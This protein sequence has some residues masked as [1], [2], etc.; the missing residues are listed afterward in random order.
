MNRALETLGWTLIHFCWQA[1]I[2]AGTYGLLDSRLRRARSE[3]RYL[4]SFVTLLLMFGTAAGTLAYETMHFPAAASSFPDATNS[5]LSALPSTSAMIA[6]GGQGRLT[7]FRLGSLLPWVDLAWLIGVVCFSTRTVAG[8]WCIQRLRRAALEEVPESVLAVCSK[9]RERLGISRIA[10]LRVCQHL[11]GP[12]TIGVARSLILL[13]AAALLSLDPEQLEAVLMHELA[14]VQRADYLWNLIQTSIETLFFFHPAV[15]WLGKRI[16][17]QRELCCD[18]LALAACADPLAY[19]TALLQIA[20]QRQQRIDLAM[21]FAGDRPQSGLRIRIARILGVTLPPA[22][23]W[24]ARPFSLAAI[25][26]ASLLFLSPLPR[27]F[28]GQSTPAIQNQAQPQAQ[29]GM[30]SL[31]APALIVQATKEEAPLQEP[32]LVKLQPDAKPAPAEAGRIEQM[33]TAGHDA[34][35]DKHAARTG[36]VMPPS[37]PGGEPFRSASAAANAVT[38]P[39]LAARMQ[40]AE[41]GPAPTAPSYLDGMRDAGYRLDLSKDFHTLTTMKSL[42]VTPEYAKA[43]GTVGLGKPTARDLI[44]L[45]SLGVTPEYIRGLK[46]SGIEPKDFHELAEEKSLAITPEYVAGLKQTGLSGLSARQLIVLKALRMTPEYAAWLKQQ[47]PQIT[48]EELRRAAILHIDQN[49]V[50]QAK[51]YGFDGKDLNELLRLKMSGLLN[52]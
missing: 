21:A 22:S 14:H 36:Q 17:H 33:R 26:I 47:F 29:I 23:R 51:A 49:F 44:R 11:P 5:V 37:A 34:E 6:A 40:A 7:F 20:E 43:M 48:A 15:W 2:L 8:W 35:I 4:L 13:P 9:L 50:A 19:A 46:Q 10:E 30:P 28:G 25:G 12:L 39:V 41:G 18:D 16:R 31:R 42:G 1:T 32:K 27:S 24:T 38:P 45:K 52:R 3:T